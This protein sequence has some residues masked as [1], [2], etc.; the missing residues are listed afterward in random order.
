MLS[1]L[2]INYPGNV[3]K[4]RGNNNNKIWELNI[5]SPS[6]NQAYSNIPCD[7]L[8]AYF[9]NNYNVNFGGRI[10]KHDNREWLETNGGGA[11]SSSTVSG[12]NTRV[13]HGALIASTNQPVDR[14]VVLSR[15]DEEIETKNSN[16]AR[17]SEVSYDNQNPPPGGITGNETSNISSFRVLPVPTWE[18]EIEKNAT[19]TKQIVMPHDKGKGTVVIGYTYNADSDA[20]PVILKLKPIF[21]FRDFHNSQNSVSKW[22]NQVDNNKLIVKCSINNNPNTIKPTLQWDNKN[23]VVS[24][25]NDIYGNYYY[26]REKD[27]GLGFK[28]DNLYNPAELKVS[29]KPGESISLTVSVEDNIKPLNIV[30]EV[31]NKSSYFNKLYQKSG[32]PETESFKLL[33]RAADQF[34]VHRNSVNGPTILAGYHWFNDWGRDTMIALPGCTLTTKRF[35]EA[36]GILKTFAQYSKNGMLPNNFPNYAGADP[37]YNT[38][39]ASMW[40]FNAL[41]S[42]IKASGA[43][44]DKSFVKEQYKELQKVVEHHL[45]GRHSG[46]ELISLNND[47][48]SIVNIQQSMLPVG[49]GDKGLGMETDG[50]IAAENGQLT[51]MDASPDGNT[52]YTPRD[53]KAVEINALWYNGLKIMADLAKDFGEDNNAEKYNNLANIVKESMKKFWNPSTGCLNDLIDI[54]RN[55]MKNDASVRPN[56]IIA[57]ALPNRAFA[58]QPEIEKSILKVVEEK[59][60]TPYGLKS[61]SAD[62]PD[63][64]P[65]YP[66]AGPGDRDPVYHQGT[67]WSWLIGPYADAYLNINDGTKKETREKVYNIMRPMLE[68]LKGNISEHALSGACIGGIAEIFDATEPHYAKG[69][70]NQAWS[71]TEALRILD[72]IQ[73]IVIEKENN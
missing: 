71:V 35:D 37:G 27:R 33:Q 43:D 22:E 26:Q 4:F 39:D 54:K 58:D 60:L 59:L 29:L 34:I 28:E 17:L 65:Y 11:Y 6:K 48:S 30:K 13:Y 32:L 42:Y 55:R 69:T 72:K 14:N 20:S 68:H 45:Y 16:I 19:I 7:T 23:I 25:T 36:K 2:G 62:H 3:C 73:D 51:W 15:I 18:Y 21:N 47:L 52:P 50:L 5:N 46:K 9:T 38:S 24:K 44:V 10:L 1:R 67:V 41:N 8:K 70:V 61:L 57:L 40:W 66:N 12:S 49:N 31:Q 63:Y 64:A 53:G 56:Q